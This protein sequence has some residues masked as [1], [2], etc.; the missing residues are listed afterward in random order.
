LHVAIASVSADGQPC[1]TPIGSLFLN[2]D[3]TGFY[4]EMY[5]KHLPR[6]ATENNRIC[7]LSVDSSKWFWLKALFK[8]KFDHY[9]GVKLY[10]KLGQKRMATEKEIARLTRRMRYTQR[11]KGHQYLWPSMQHIREI[12]FEKAEVI[13]FGH[14]TDHL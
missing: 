8:G 4:F 3:Q 5:P 10:G 14:M 7:V 6:H 13:R 12:K 2:N 1:T 9:P 11:L